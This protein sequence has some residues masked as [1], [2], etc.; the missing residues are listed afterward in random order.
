M[1]KSTLILIL[2]II[3]IAI[4]GITIYNA[5]SNDEFFNAPITTCIS[6]F[7]ASG[8]SFYV[9]QRQTDRR[10]QKEIF[11]QL[12]ESMKELVD[13]EK[14]YHLAGRS[15]EEILMQKRAMNNKIDFVKKYSDHFSIKTEISF[16]ED[17]FNEYVAVIDGH[18]NDLETLG[19]LG[20]ELKRPLSLMSQKIFEMMFNLYS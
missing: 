14:S 11:V 20:A 10:K 2:T 5:I 4:L 3:C 16:L 13:D 18:I 8:L 9:V 19:K 7:I 6:L 15:K 12:L 17:K 1:K